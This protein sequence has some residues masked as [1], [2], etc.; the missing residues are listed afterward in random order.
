MSAIRVL[1]ADDH[2]ILRTGVRTL[3]AATPGI[4]VVGE[5]SSGRQ[6]VELT[7]EH[8]P[9]VVVMDIGMR[10]LDGLQATELIKK[11]M[12]A[13]KVVVL[14]MHD[15]ADFVER[16]LR[17]GASGYL[18]KDAVAEELHLAIRAVAA[19]GTYLSPSISQHVLNGYLQSLGSPPRPDIL[20][21]RQQQILDLIGAGKST[22]DI[23]YQ[24][25]LSV[26]TVEA[27]RAQM[28]Q[29]LGVRNVTNLIL[30]ASR[31][32]LITLRR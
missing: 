10:D 18:V 25:N 31:R 20:T 17:M 6:A 2:L 1:I 16:A 22:K 9:D 7:R 8:R 3:L 14:S 23:A 4:E 28:M 19:G 27:H 12:P 11:E 21:P 32:G 24:L 30:E 26:K 5:A 29:R 15:T 13:V